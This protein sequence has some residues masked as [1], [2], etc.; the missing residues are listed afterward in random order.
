MEPQQAQHRR[1][2]RFARRGTIALAVLLLPGIW[3]P[4]TLAA[5]NAIVSCDKV[6]RKLQ[7]LEVTGETLAFNT[8]EHMSD[9]DQA[10]FDAPA[11][12]TILLESEIVTPVLLLTPR[13]AS[14]LREVFS[15]DV[16]ADGETT[17]VGDSPARPRS[18]TETAPVS[19]VARDD[20]PSQIPRDEAANRY[21]PRFQRQM[22]RTDI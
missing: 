18:D 2:S 10:D 3:S 5:S 15:S 19:P 11:N 21:M 16:A 9:N 17:E 12:T 14:I 7:T 20:S 8:V 4:A 1:A 6:A 13:V 22:Y